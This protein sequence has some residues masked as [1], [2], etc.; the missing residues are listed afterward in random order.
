MFLLIFFFFCRIY[1]HK[2]I[3][4]NF[5]RHSSFQ[6]FNSDV[7][8]TYNF[9]QNIKLIFPHG[10]EWIVEFLLK[11]FSEQRY[12]YTFSLNVDIIANLKRIQIFR[13]EI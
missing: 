7:R 1:H 3:T 9:G 10:I 12:N 5:E 4:T 6:W 11:R 8:T 2:L 13:K